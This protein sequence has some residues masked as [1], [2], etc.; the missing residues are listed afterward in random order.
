MTHDDRGA[1]G[2]TAPGCPPDTA[3]RAANAWAVEAGIALPTHV[4][5]RTC[6]RVT[7]GNPARRVLVEPIR[8]LPVLEY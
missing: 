6:D 3:T 7:A 4:W 1:V 8:P 5:R 2:L